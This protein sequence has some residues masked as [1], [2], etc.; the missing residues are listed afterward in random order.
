MLETEVDGFVYRCYYYL[1]NKIK[2]AGIAARRLPTPLKKSLHLDVIVSSNLI[3]QVFFCA[4][5]LC[6]AY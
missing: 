3:A 5:A 6:F 2:C 1:R 4:S